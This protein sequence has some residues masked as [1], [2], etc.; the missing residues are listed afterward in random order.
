MPPLTL[1]EIGKRVKGKMETDGISQYEMANRLDVSQPV[2]S[3]ALNGSQNQRKTLF[4]I[5][6]QMGFE[7]SEEPRYRFEDGA[8]K[9]GND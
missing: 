6:R 2:V 9:G 4:R 8:T 7:I 5:A 3:D 1:S